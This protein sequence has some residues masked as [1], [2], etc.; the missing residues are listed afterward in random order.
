MVRSRYWPSA[1]YQR[2]EQDVSGGAG[3]SGKAEL[4]ALQKLTLHLDVSY[5]LFSQPHA[6]QIR[7]FSKFRV[8]CPPK[9]SNGCLQCD[10]V[11]ELHQRHVQRIVACIS[12]VGRTRHSGKIRG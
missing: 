12:K 4:I 5:P 1:V 9:S 3:S 2:R 7:L 10:I 8:H 6:R 11:E